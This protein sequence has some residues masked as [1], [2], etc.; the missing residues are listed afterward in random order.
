MTEL[1]RDLTVYL[2]ILKC[3]RLFNNQITKIRS[4]L[5]NGLTKLE[6]IWLDH[7]K[8]KKLDPALFTGLIS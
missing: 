5:F 2:K 7:Y 3:I 4:S 8:I 1:K 6:V